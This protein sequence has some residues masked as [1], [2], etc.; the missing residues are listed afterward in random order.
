MIRRTQAE[1]SDATTSKLVAA[2]QQLFGRDGYAATTIGAVA[3]VAGMT[4]GAAYH[5]FLNKATLFREV[6]IREQEEISAALLSAAAQEPD[7]WAALL[8][9][10]QTFLEHCLDPGF[11]QIVL[12]DGPAVLGWEAVREIQRDHTLRVLTEGV[13][14]VTADGGDPGIRSQLIFGA[15]CEAGMLLARSGDPR[16]DLPAV[17]TE[18]ARLLSSLSLEPHR[19]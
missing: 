16:G 1:R 2:A 6:F 15:L 10:C 18:A 11:R 13:R 9:G 4:K 7:P 5:H 12:L 19:T 14:A 8:R 17:V 3:T